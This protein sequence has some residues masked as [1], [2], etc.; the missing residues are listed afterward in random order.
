M[1][2]EGCT[3]D[4]VQDGL[5]CVRPYKVVVKGSYGRG[6][7]ELMVCPSDKEKDAGL[8]YYKCGQGFHAVGPVCWMSCPESTPVSSGMLCCDTEATC[9]FATI[10]MVTSVLSSVLSVASLVAS[11]PVAPLAAAVT[12]G[13]VASMALSYT[14]PVCG[15]LP[16]AATPAPLPTNGDSYRTMVVDG[17]E[18]TFRFR[19]R[20][21]PG[22]P[23]QFDVTE[24]L[25]PELASPKANKCWK[26]T[27]T[28]CIP[29]CL[30]GARVPRCSCVPCQQIWLWV[31]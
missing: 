31:L 1:K 17:R 11:G 2:T 30:R 19:P 5:Y 3:G 13:T 6:W 4:Y 23:P 20:D 8:C 10:G 21:P 25:G 7:G 22:S 12:V 26:W 16:P 28:R 18:V 14:L 24:Y 27:T 29:G 15:Q 9:A